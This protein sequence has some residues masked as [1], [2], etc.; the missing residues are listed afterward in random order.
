MWKWK[1]EMRLIKGL[2]CPQKERN[3]TFCG[4]ATRSPTDTKA[5]VPG[6]VVG[7]MAKRGSASPRVFIT[8]IE[9]QKGSDDKKGQKIDK[10]AN[11]SKGPGDC[12][13]GKEAGPFFP[14]GLMCAGRSIFPFRRSFFP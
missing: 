9:S 3:F 8:G 10:G 5:A 12:L 1:G 4:D 13:G 2:R 6:V 14:L 7:K 11:K